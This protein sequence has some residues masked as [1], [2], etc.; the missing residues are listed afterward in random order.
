MKLS[1]MFTVDC[2][3]STEKKVLDLFQDQKSEFDL[4]SEFYQ[5]ILRYGKFDD[6]DY[7]APWDFRVC[8]LQEKP[9]EEKNGTEKDSL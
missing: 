2:N 7:I 1:F 5:M 9:T 4:L 6:T 3:E 8:K